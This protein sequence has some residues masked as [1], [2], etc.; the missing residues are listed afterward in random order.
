MQY[1]PRVL[2]LSRNIDWTNAV[3]VG[4]PNPAAPQSSGLFGNPFPMRT[5]ADR[6]K[7]IEQY[8]EWVNTSPS[9]QRVREA[10]PTLKGKDLVCWC[11]PRA[12]HADVLLQLANGHGGASLPEAPT[13]ARTKE[14]SMKVI[15]CGSRDYTDRGLL[16]Q[17]LDAL[18]AEAGAVTIIHGAARGADGLAGRWARER[19][20]QVQE[21]PA[22]WDKYGKRAGFLRNTKMLQEGKPHLVIGFYSD[23]NA[24]STGTAMMLDI[25][26]KAG[27]PTR[28]YPKPFSGGNAPEPEPM[29]QG[30]S[31]TNWQENFRLAEVQRIKAAFGP[32]LGV[33]GGVTNHQLKMYDRTPADWDI[34]I[35]ETA[36]KW[37]RSD[38]EQQVDWE[39]KPVARLNGEAVPMKALCTICRD[40]SIWFP[41]ES[42]HECEKSNYVFTQRVP[43][44]PVVW[45]R[46]PAV[47]PNLQDMEDTDGVQRPSLTWEWVE[48]G[49]IHLDVA[50]QI[51]FKW[52]SKKTNKEITETVDYRF[53]SRKMRSGTWVYK[54]IQGE[55]PWF[56]PEPEDGVWGIDGWM[57]DQSFIQ[58]AWH[59]K[60]DFVDVSGD[61]WN[62]ENDWENSDLDDGIDYEDDDEESA[63]TRGVPQHNSTVYFEQI[64]SDST[65]WL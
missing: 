9:A 29:P 35:L 18:L 17:V 4:R 10:I 62:P 50:D 11:A 63:N 5:E 1:Q 34:S 20:Q 58:D 31:M 40:C 6:A 3:Y 54:E 44:K 21:F 42:V 41:T 15:V 56:A 36:D 24:P 26:N 61:D 16:N 48:Q 59:S 55:D 45:T 7:V 25:S 28:S 39:R 19:G 8:K 52:T 53:R 65:V 33:S 13:V 14:T 38:F 43:M 60:P 47:I 57:S 22:E 23:P 27:V 51:T 12:C 2:R 37:W 32:T 64:A 30:G 49:A 46:P